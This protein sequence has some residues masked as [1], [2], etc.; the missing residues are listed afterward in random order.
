MEE[1]LH[2]PQ[3]NDDELQRPLSRVAC[4]R[5]LPRTPPL[6]CWHGARGADPAVQDFLAAQLQSEPSIEYEKFE[7][8]LRSHP[9]LS[10]FHSEIMQYR[11]PLCHS[12]PVSGVA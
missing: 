7:A 11:H 3:Q 5:T 1:I 12:K 4:G 6:Q 8:W 9:E 10:P 2:H